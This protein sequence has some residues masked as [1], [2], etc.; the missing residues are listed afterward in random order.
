MLVLGQ[1]DKAISDGQQQ[2]ADQR[3]IEQR[4]ERGSEWPVASR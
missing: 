1:G 2:D 3:R 4:S